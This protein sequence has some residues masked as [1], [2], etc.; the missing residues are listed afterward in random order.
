MSE[1]L[2]L[3]LIIKY[4]ISP[5]TSVTAS[6]AVGF[7]FIISYLF[8]S[9]F[10]IRLF[11]ILIVCLFTYLESAFQKI[12]VLYL[13]YGQ[14]LAKIMNEFA[15]KLSLTIINISTLTSAQSILLYYSAF[16]IVGALLCS[17]LVYSI[18]RKL[19]Q[20]DYEFFSII[21]LATISNIESSEESKH[22]GKIKYGLLFILVFIVL[23]M[24]IVVGFSDLI[25]LIVRSVV[26]ILIWIFIVLPILKNLLSSYLK[27]KESKFA[28]K[29]DEVKLLFPKIKNAIIWSSNTLKNEPWYK[30]IFIVPYY[31]LGIVIFSQE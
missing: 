11:S 3:V 18:F 2:I 29:L 28:I 23:V 30:K 5:H 27:K 13:I 7:Q 12:L 9:F 17:Y 8:Y 20:T 1:A 15:E 24:A 4:S 31:V 22:R 10:G 25:Y 26:V 16:Y 14:N 19:I 21:S 6:L